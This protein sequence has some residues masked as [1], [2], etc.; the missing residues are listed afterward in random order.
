M[1]NLRPLWTSEMNNSEA[2]DSQIGGFSGIYYGS[3]ELDLEYFEGG[4]GYLEHGNVA[5][6]KVRNAS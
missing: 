3:Q 6:V 2:W 4:L 1:K 5:A